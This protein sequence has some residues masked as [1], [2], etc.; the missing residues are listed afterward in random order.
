MGK[1][2]PSILVENINKDHISL[3]TCSYA[4]CELDRIFS[5][6]TIIDNPFILKTLKNLKGDLFW[7][8]RIK[9]K[10]ECQ[11]DGTFLMNKLGDI[12]DKKNI[13][14]ICQPNPYGKKNL[15]QLIV[16][17]KRFNFNEIIKDQVLIRLPKV[18]KA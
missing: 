4:I 10:V 18:I 6:D 8:A 9:S 17:Y 5:L 16:F 14:V 3:M 2:T 12:F 11:G 13:T 1:Y 15:R 7:F